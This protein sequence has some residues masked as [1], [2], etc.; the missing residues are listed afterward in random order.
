MDVSS[1]GTTWPIDKTTDHL[2]QRGVWRVFV[3]LGSPE[4]ATMARNRKAEGVV[5][6]Q[7]PEDIADYRYLGTLGRSCP[8][9]PARRATFGYTQPAVSFDRSRSLRLCLSI[10][11]DAY[12]EVCSPTVSSSVFSYTQASPATS[13]GKLFGR[14]AFAD[15]AAYVRQVNRN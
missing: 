13:L 2:K 15:L 6:E 9:G 7:I 8:L 11:R 4:A 14:V 5:S 3:A 10:A 12:E 1:E